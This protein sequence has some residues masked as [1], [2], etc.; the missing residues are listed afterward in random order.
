MRPPVASW[1]QPPTKSVWRDK[2]S[3]WGGGKP[4]VVAA[5]ALARQ[6][7]RGNRCC[8]STWHYEHACVSL[9]LLA[10]PPHRYY[11]RLLLPEMQLLHL[12]LEPSRLTWSH[13]SST[14]TI[15]Y[16]KPPALV[17]EVGV[18]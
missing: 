13:A 10:A 11:K 7:C 9:P 17:A 2:A 3:V 15:N 16:A 1:S 5:H 18:V 8:G 4:R 14:L 6:Q 12:V